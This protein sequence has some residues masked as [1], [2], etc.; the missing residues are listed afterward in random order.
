MKTFF[1]MKGYMN[2]RMKVI[3]GLADATGMY[4]RCLRNIHTEFLANDGNFLSLIKLHR[5]K[6]QN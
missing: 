1:N 6:G 3:A 4:E 5:F 2:K